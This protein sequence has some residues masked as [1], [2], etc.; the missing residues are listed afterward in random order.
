MKIHLLVTGK[1]FI[2][3]ACVVTTYEHT[4][5]REAIHETGGYSDPNWAAPSRKSTLSDRNEIT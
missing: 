5:L 4:K 1:S 3:L 2:L